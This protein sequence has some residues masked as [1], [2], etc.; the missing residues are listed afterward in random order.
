MQA[1]H[2]GDDFAPMA[3]Q[4]PDLAARQVDLAYYWHAVNDWS[5]AK[6]E[7]RTARGWLATIR[8]FA[9]RDEDSGRLR[10]TSPP[11]AYA[12]GGEVFERLFEEHQRQLAQRSVFDQI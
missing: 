9:R 1:L 10:L 11:D 3:A 6:N 8:T 4:F 12:R 5:D 7:M 2:D